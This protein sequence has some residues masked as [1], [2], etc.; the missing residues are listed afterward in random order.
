MKKQDVKN[1]KISVLFIFRIFFLYYFLLSTCLTS[2]SSQTVKKVGIFDYTGGICFNVE[3]E[4][5]KRLC[6]FSLYFFLATRSYALMFFF[7]Y[8]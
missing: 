3:M 6:C 2:H 5:K 1:L 4:K 7:N 8:S